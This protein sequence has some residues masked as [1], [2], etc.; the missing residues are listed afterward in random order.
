MIL[1]SYHEKI[2]STSSFS[3]YLGYLERFLK[4]TP[5]IN[6]YNSS[7]IGANIEGTILDPEIIEWE[8]EKKKQT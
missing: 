4:K 6:W 1:N 8:N 3:S 2:P 5:G 7:N